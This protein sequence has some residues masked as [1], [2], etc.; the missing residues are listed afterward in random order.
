LS[1]VAIT[2][3]PRSAGSVQEYDDLALAG[4]GFSRGE[5]YVLSSIL[6]EIGNNRAASWASREELPSLQ[7]AV[8]VSQKDGHVIAENVRGGQVEE[9][10]VIEITGRHRLDG[11]EQCRLTFVKRSK[12]LKIPL[13]VANQHLDDASFFNGEIRDVI[14]VEIANRERED[15]QRT[16]HGFR[17]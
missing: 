7:S 10:V 17:G 15:Q 9:P 3:E 14:V 6:I 16:G 8:S 12:R 13:P 4:T 5:G 2:R 1:N 11:G